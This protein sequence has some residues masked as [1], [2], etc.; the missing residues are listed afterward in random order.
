MQRITLLDTPY[1]HAQFGN[2]V[3]AV[4]I[5]SNCARALLPDELALWCQVNHIEWFTI[6]VLYD[7]STTL[8]HFRIYAHVTDS[9]AT[10]YLLRWGNSYTYEQSHV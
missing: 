8:L 10:Y 4:E 9:L 2:Y 1:N 7:P 5:S 6:S 3:N